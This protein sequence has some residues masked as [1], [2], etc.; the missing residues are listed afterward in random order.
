[1]DDFFSNLNNAGGIDFMD[2]R[3]KG[4]ASTLVGK[5]VTIMDFGFIKSD[6]G[7]DYAVFYVQE[8]AEHFFFGNSVL[9]DKLHTVENA[10]RKDEIHLHPATFTTQVSKKGPRKG[11]TYTMVTFA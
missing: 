9:T 7:G 1:M 6:D 11:K 8:D 5:T 10:G 4:D 3:T 2:E